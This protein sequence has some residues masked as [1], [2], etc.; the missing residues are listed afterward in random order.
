[1]ANFCTKCGTPL[2]PDGVCPNCPAPAKSPFGGF[3]IPKPAGGANPGAGTPGTGTPGVAQ[4]FDISQIKGFIENVKNRMGLGDPELNKGDA[5]E[6]DKLIIPECVSANEN[7][8]PVK[9]YTVAKLRNRL[10]GITYSKAIGRIQVTNKRVIF[11]APG[12]CPAGRTTL[13]HEFTID[14]IAGLEARREYVPNIADII[15]G[16]IVYSFAAGLALSFFTSGDMKLDTIKT[17]GTILSIGLLVPFF[18]INKKWLLKL[19]ING[20][21]FGCLLTPFTLNSDNFFFILIGLL[22]IG[23]SLA[24]LIIYSIRPNLVIKIKTNAATDS[25]IDIQRKKFSLFGKGANEEHTGY[26]EVL[27]EAD[28]E[29]S[30]RELFAVINDIKTL[31]DFGIEKWRKN[32]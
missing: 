26:T 29:K 25:A 12:R 9:Q 8:I 4:N 17:L 14:E 1:M 31:G 32:Q 6:K 27:P 19:F 18:V 15:I 7:E 3:T 16:L 28:A 10:L 20:L 13:Q 22:V 11:R 2:G 30:I 21:S 5:Y 24:N 23:I